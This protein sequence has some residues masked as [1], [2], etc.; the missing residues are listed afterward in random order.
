MNSNFLS[1]F[2]QLQIFRHP[3]PF[4]LSWSFAH[5]QQYI[6]VKVRVHL[7]FSQNFKSVKH[8]MWFRVQSISPHPFQFFPSRKNT[9]NF[10]PSYQV[11]FIPSFNFI[12]ALSSFVMLLLLDT[13]LFLFHSFIHSL[14]VNHFL[15]WGEINK[16]D[17]FGEDTFSPSQL[18]SLKLVKCSGEWKSWFSRAFFSFTSPLPMMW[19]L[20]Y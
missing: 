9:K 8:R 16:A 6:M 7:R 13:G 4:H 11:T 12:L 18:E 3:S 10:L 2:S 19:S 5:L 1:R 14:Q 17:L 15:P 20:R